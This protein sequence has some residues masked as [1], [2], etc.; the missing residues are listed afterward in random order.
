[1]NWG[2]KCV[3]H[4]VT[5]LRFPRWQSF[6]LQFIG[7][8]HSPWVPRWTKAESFFWIMSSVS[9]WRKNLIYQH[10]SRKNI[11]VNAGR[12]Q[13][14]LFAAPFKRQEVSS[15]YRHCRQGPRVTKINYRRT[16]F[17]NEER[18]IVAIEEGG[19]LSFRC[20]FWRKQNVAKVLGLPR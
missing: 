2:R 18:H 13:F 1:M 12:T 5:I 16:Q 8:S 3:D 10:K 20:F 9:S 7:E 11:F 6:S 4:V 19:K 14:F 15:L 17:Q